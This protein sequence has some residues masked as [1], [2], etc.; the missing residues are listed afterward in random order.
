MYTSAYKSQFV[1]TIRS[2]ALHLVSCA[3]Y[4]RNMHANHNFFGNNTS[5]NINC[6][7]R[8]WQSLLKDAISQL[9]RCMISPAPGFTI[10]IQNTCMRCEFPS[11]QA[12]GTHR[13][14]YDHALAR[15]RSSRAVGACRTPFS[16]ECPTAACGTRGI[17]HSTQHSGERV[18][19]AQQARGDAVCSHCGRVRACTALRA[20]GRACGCHSA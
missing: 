8:G 3:E 4:A 20:R 13:H 1:L 9:S 19:R 16:A 12:F 2:P 15:K 5:P 10:K 18:C 6:R 17:A 7:T 11:G 14:M